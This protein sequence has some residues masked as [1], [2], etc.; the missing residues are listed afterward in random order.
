MKKKKNTGAN[1][2]HFPYYCMESRCFFEMKTNHRIRTQDFVLQLVA[3]C[4]YI[5][6][7]IG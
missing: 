5:H 3:A 6:S 4:N 7:Y 2:R 1:Q